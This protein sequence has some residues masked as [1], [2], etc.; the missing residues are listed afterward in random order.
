MAF[1]CALHRVTKCSNAI[2]KEFNAAELVCVSGGHVRWEL[3]GMQQL[4][5][6]AMRC[7]PG[8]LDSHAPFHRYLLLQRLPRRRKALALGVCCIFPSSLQVTWSAGSPL[9]VEGLKGFF[10][11]SSRKRLLLSITAVESGSTCDWQR[12]LPSAV[13]HGVPVVV[14]PPHPHPPKL[15]VLNRGG[16]P[17]VPSTSSLNSP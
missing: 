13:C 6:D 5:Y 15:T 11:G 10:R 8:D 17:K 3:G 12:L 1:H 16:P 14:P 9:R 7:L 2:N 4:R